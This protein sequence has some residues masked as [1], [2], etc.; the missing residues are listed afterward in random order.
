MNP[1]IPSLRLGALVCSLSA[2]LAPQPGHADPQADAIAAVQSFNAAFGRKDIDG[3]V[4]HCIDGGVVFDLRP[5]HADQSAPQSLTQELKEKWY[6]VT[7]ILFAAT[8]SY[9]RNVEII[10]S[11]ATED[12][13]TVWTKTTAT[14][15]MPKSGKPSTN[16]FNEVYFLVHTPKGWK[17]G[18]MM[19]N[20]GTDS[21]STAAP[22]PAPAARK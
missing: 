21:L 11:R 12:M 2:I 13:A 16:S 17:I 20:R 10:D 22:A 14:T 6:G 5:A 3:L 9:T 7:P 15:V 1:G 19:D 4:A 18:A 8:A